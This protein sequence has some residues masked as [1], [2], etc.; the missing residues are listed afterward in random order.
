MV[1][2]LRASG[3]FQNMSLKSTQR[4]RVSVQVGVAAAAAVAALVGFSGPATA[5]PSDQVVQFNPT[6]ARV[7]GNG[8]AAIINAETVPQPQAG[9]LGVRVKIVQTG[10]NCEGYRVSVRWKNLDTG[11][12]NGQ[13]HKVDSNGVIE[14]APDGVITG[15]GMAPGPGRVEATIVATTDSYPNHWDLEQLSGMAWITLNK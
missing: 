7:P 13:S 12:A 3:E 11:V 9:Q 4:Q 14:H 15:M 2:D 1:N 8:C 10:E 6:L 5:L